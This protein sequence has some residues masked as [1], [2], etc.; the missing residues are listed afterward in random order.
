VR[1]KFIGGSGG[2]SVLASLADSNV[3]EGGGGGEDEMDQWELEQLK[4]GVASAGS[5]ATTM[6][7]GAAAAAA[8][9]RARA[10]VSP[11]FN[12]SLLSPTV[13]LSFV[14]TAQEVLCLWRERE[15]RVCACEL[16]CVASGGG[17]LGGRREA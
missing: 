15:M 4:K 6:G 16:S 5:A 8:D 11:R 13:R 14:L 2:P 12:S 1:L 9:G 10:A 3:D 17:D 7:A